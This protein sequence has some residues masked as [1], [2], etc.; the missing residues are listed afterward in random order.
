MKRGKSLSVKLWMQIFPFVPLNIRIHDLFSFLFCLNDSMNQISV[1]D[2]ARTPRKPRNNG[3]MVD[4]HTDR[5]KKSLFQFEKKNDAS[6]DLISSLTN[7]FFHL[8]FLDFIHRNYIRGITGEV[9]YSQ[10][11]TLIWHGRTYA[12]AAMSACH[13]STAFF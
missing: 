7:V 6:F 11:L 3:L 10:Q 5:S 4:R 8:F 9:F 12:T 1:M 13:I 2:T